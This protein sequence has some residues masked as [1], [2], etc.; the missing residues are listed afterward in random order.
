MI[1]PSRKFLSR[2]EATYALGLMDA[3]NPQQPEAV[4]AEALVAVRIDGEVYEGPERLH[5][6]LVC[7]LASEGV[8]VTGDGTTFEEGW[9]VE[10]TP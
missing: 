10:V 8:S 7:R 1:G 3:A 9:T 5:A 4:K 2:V 6:L